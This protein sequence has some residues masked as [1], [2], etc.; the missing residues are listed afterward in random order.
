MASRFGVEAFS[1][2][3][4]PNILDQPSDGSFQERSFGL[5]GSQSDISGPT[6]LLYAARLLVEPTCGAAVCL[7]F[8]RNSALLMRPLC[9]SIVA[10]CVL[11]LSVSR[12]WAQDAAATAPPATAPVT[13]P[14]EQ[15]PADKAFAPIRSM[16]DN[17]VTS[18]RNNGGMHKD[19]ESALRYVRE[20]AAAFT[21]QFP[22][23]PRGLAVELQVSMWLNDDAMIDE[24]FTRLAAALP[25]NNA[26]PLSQ[27]QFDLNHNRFAKAI[28]VLKA[29]KFDP[30]KTPQA[31]ISLSDALFAE[32]QFVE[33]ADALKMIP[34]D[35]LEK[36][37]FVKL[38]V[39]ESLK[40]RDGYEDIWLA[41]KAVRE[42]ETAANDLPQAVIKTSR[43]EIV[44]ELFE[45][46][47][48]N[49]VANFVKLAESGF[50]NGTKFHRVIPNFMAQ[51]GDPNSKDG[52]TG[53]PGQGDPGYCIPDEVGRDDERKHFTGTLAMAK[54]A[55]PNTGGCQ[56]YITVTP[57]PHLNGIHTVFGRTL[58]GLDIVRGLKQDDV[59]ESITIAR[60]RE[61][62]YEPTTLPLP[63]AAT[64]P[65][66]SQPASQ[67]ESEP[68]DSQPATV[69]ATP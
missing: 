6:L 29:G 10:G 12:A 46:Q 54:T 14:A 24:L 55:A 57:T 65:A 5:A 2:S 1:R 32:E 37:V 42:K 43:G 7:H 63:G 62:P 40:R 38:Q 53:V 23:D 44:V 66:T 15:S 30:A 11:A 4:E 68:A 69:P 18:L 34:S 48:P 28:A 26:I 35:V 25:E 47:A 17:L 52:A 67:P 41:E 45:N 27:A 9:F 50:Y 60:K 64:Q 56:F 33:A 20:K 61:H 19:D 36:D 51:G 22:S 3:R 13:L 16:L 31:F 21:Q 49:T 59:I 39:D 58:N 8:E